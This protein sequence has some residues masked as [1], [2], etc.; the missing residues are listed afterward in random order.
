MRTQWKLTWWCRD[1][2]SDEASSGCKQGGEHD[3]SEPSNVEPVISGRD[4]VGKL[5]PDGRN[6]TLLS[7]DVG[8]STHAQ[9]G[10]GL[11]GARGRSLQ[12]RH[13]LGREVHSGTRRRTEAS[14]E[15][16]LRSSESL[17]CGC[18]ESN[19]DCGRELHLEI[20]FLFVAFRICFRVVF[21]LI[22]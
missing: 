21:E 3:G 17:A 14:L 5:V 19:D 13:S 12:S 18:E 9:L 11:E 2:G 8:E 20:V 10:A 4:P 6:I 7:V 15:G 16:R 22:L 1:E